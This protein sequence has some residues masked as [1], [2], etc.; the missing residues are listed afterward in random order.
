MPSFL[1]I[2][3]TTVLA[4]TKRQKTTRL[5][6]QPQKKQKKTMTR[7]RVSYCDGRAVSHSCDVLIDGF[8]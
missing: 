5:K 3:T 8:P 1:Q 4:Q 2:V 7:K 6:R